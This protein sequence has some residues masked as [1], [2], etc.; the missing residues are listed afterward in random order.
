VGRVLYGGGWGLAR[1]WVW[2]GVGRFGGGGVFR[3]GRV[4]LGVSWHLMTGRGFRTR[5]DGLMAV[6]GAVD[7]LG[8]SSLVEVPH[9]SC[10]Q[11]E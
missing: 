1:T 4:S 7:E 9:K 5:R 6:L 3:C 11:E 10:R 2:V 8:S